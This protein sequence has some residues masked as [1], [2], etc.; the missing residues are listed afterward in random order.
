MTAGEGIFQASCAV[1]HRPGLA[2]FPQLPGNTLVQGRNPDTVL[3][4]ILSGSQSIGL[5]NT[6]MPYSMPAFAPLNDDQIAAVT[7]YIRNAWGNR[8]P[9]VTAAQV[10][11]LRPTVGH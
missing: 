6:K 11:A 8:A 5:K 1:C 2:G 3:R 10:K 4:V 9:A 7:T